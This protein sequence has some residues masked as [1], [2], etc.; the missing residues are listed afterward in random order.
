MVQ[1]CPRRVLFTPPPCVCVLFNQLAVS[2]SRLSTDS[3]SAHLNSPGGGYYPILR[4][5]CVCPPSTSCFNRKDNDGKRCRN[6]ATALI[7]CCD[8]QPPPPAR[9]PPSVLRA[10][11]PHQSIFRLAPHTTLDLSLALLSSLSCVP[12]TCQREAPHLHRCRPLSQ[13][14][15]PRRKTKKVGRITQTMRRRRQLGR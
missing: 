7:Y 6:E 11:Q 1:L 15:G 8:K 10:R 5:L 12:Q 13:R 4:L 3:E 14:P 9:A 2:L